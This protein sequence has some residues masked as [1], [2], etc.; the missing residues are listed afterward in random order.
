MSRIAY[1]QK[2]DALLGAAARVFAE[3]GFH[4][5]SMRDL[6]RLT[7]VS[8]AGWYYYVASKDELLCVIQERTWSA[9]GD[10]VA[11]ALEEAATPLDRLERFVRAHLAFAAVRAA[12]MR[13][14]VREEGALTGELAL[15]VGAVRALHAHSLDAVL[16]GLERVAGGAQVA[17]ELAARALVGMINA[18][19][20]GA[21]AY[22]LEPL[23]GDVCRLFLGGYLGG[24][25]APMGAL[26]P[27]HAS[28]AAPLPA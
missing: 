20:E 6:S 4:Q 16:S 13:V 12:E 1:D 15:R 10:A 26:A 18:L 3:R 19:G 27:G 7:G 8:L 11:R 2:L 28:Y 9:L 22:D 24:A 5:T 14:L 23:A 17:R 21:P 25:A